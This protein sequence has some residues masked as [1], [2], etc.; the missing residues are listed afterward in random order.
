MKR[1]LTLIFYIMATT[2]LGNAQTVYSNLANQYAL[3]G[4][5]NKALELE[6]EGL[7]LLESV[8]GTIECP[9]YAA[10]LSN[11]IRWNS[12]IG[13]YS[14]A[15]D[16]SEQLK[17]ILNTCPENEYN[18]ILSMDNLSIFLFRIG[19]YS[20]ALSYENKVRDYIVE[21]IGTQSYEYADCL[22]KLAYYISKTENIST[23]FNLVQES[24]DIISNLYG[25]NNPIYAFSLN[26]LCE[27]YT[28]IGDFQEAIN[29]GSR[30]LQ[31][32]ESNYG[33]ENYYYMNSLSNLGNYHGK[34]A[35]YKDA[36]TNIEEAVAIAKKLYGDDNMQVSNKLH[37]LAILYSKIGDNRTA[38]DIEEKAFKIAQLHL[39]KNSSEYASYLDNLSIYNDRLGNVDDALYYEK[40]S[41]EIRRVICGEESIEYSKSLDHMV[42]FYIEI[43]DLKNAHDYASKALTIREKI[44]GNEHP[45]CASSLTQVATVQAC[46]G[47]IDEALTSTWSAHIIQEKIFGR[48]HPDVIQSTFQMAFYLYLKRD[49][50]K[51]YEMLNNGMSSLIYNIRNAFTYLS[52]NERN[53]YY[54]SKRIEFEKYLPQYACSFPIDKMVGLAYNGVLFSKGVILNTNIELSYFLGSSGSNDLLNIYNEMKRTKLELNQLYNVPISERVVETDSLELYANKLEHLL[55]QQSLEY[56]DYTRNL[57]ITWEN[58]QLHLG[59]NDVS[60]E[61]VS[62]PNTDN[63][64]KYIAYVLRK[65]EIYPKL[66]ELFEENEIKCFLDDDN[67][68]KIYSDRNASNLVWGK[69]K[70]YLEGIENIFFSPDGILHYIAIEYLPDFE[71]VG[72]LSDR[73]QFY[74][75]SSTR[76]IVNNKHAVSNNS[77]M[78]YGGIRFDTDIDVMKNES[79][80]YNHESTRGNLDKIGFEDSFMARFGLDYLP[81]TLDEAINIQETLKSNNHPSSILT[82]HEASEE[83]VKDLSGKAIGIMHL[84]T[85]GFYWTPDEAERRVKFNNNL[86]FM[87]QYSDE[88]IKM[89][90]EDKALSRAGLFMA[91]AKNVLS[92]KHLPDGVDDGI[93]TA[94]EISYIDLRG[95]DLV[96]LSACQTGMGDLNGDGVFGLQRG[97]KKAGANSI[98]MTLWNVDDEA[99][100]IL[101]IEFYKNYLGGMSKQKSLNEAQRV[102]RETPGFEDPEYWAA[103]ILLDAL[104]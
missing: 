97:F 69:L 36:I 103:F 29:Q 2:L 51:M 90:E 53:L 75:L 98:L 1:L 40:K 91:G 34:M 65:G 31:I 19:D 30:I 18:T 35:N 25:E 78:V 58:V 83:S 62:F 49:Y 7:H 87:V 79:M 96:V 52:S 46:S 23:S 64:T 10:G 57:N 71:S 13:N 26:T 27:L 41:L 85:H 89:N 42:S 102:V 37:N 43:N 86:R 77:A 12:E 94:Q 28:I 22:N 14:N 5:Y 84:S 39:N 21:N 47:N 8:R 99:T 15:K 101:M 67:P 66:V 95:L 24:L 81:F 82:G 33:K 44:L 11:I 100:Q 38:L 3:E 68:Q 45:F 9:E 73:F 70:P 88:D 4:D 16:L 56:G 63:I 104:N 55:L 60:I 93:L 54:G 48:Y 72:R 20:G 6:Q 17:K 74:R 61:F 80:K 59:S 32:Y 92:G 76:E 50:E